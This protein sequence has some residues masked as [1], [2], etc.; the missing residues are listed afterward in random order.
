MRKVVDFRKNRKGI[1][2]LGLYLNTALVLGIY[3]FMVGEYILK[4]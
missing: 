1:P 3:F 4:T 2:L